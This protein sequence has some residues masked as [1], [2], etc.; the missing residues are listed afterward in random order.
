VEEGRD[1]V[2]AGAKGLRLVLFDR[3]KVGFPQ[4]LAPCGDEANLCF[5]K[6]T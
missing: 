3:G 4:P 5:L 6:R 1:D 2:N